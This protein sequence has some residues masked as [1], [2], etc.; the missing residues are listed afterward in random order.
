MRIIKES[1]V[2]AYW[3]LHPDAEPALAKWLDLAR[4]AS[5]TSLQDLRRQYPSADGVTVASGNTVT[6]FNIAGNKYRLIVCIKYQWAVI[7][8]RDFLTLA[9]YGKNTWKMRH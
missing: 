7:Y 3:R 5:W 9:E 2:R 8:I 1:T 4:K 6:V